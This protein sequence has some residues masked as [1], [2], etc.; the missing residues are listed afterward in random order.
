MSSSAIG[1]KSFCQV[2]SCSRIAPRDY[3]IV[4]MTKL[5]RRELE[6]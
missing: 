6:R 5:Y 2:P 1:P 3:A 4:D